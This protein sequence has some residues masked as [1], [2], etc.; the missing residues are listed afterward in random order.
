MVGGAALAVLECLVSAALIT[1]HL[2]HDRALGLLLLAAFGK[3]ALT[4]TLFWTPIMVFL[5][6]VRWVSCRRVAPRP[7]EPFL[8]AAF[9]VLSGV[10]VG[11][12]DLDMVRRA[13][14]AILAAA[15]VGTIVGAMVAYA[16]VGVLRRRCG[17]SRFARR[18]SIIIITCAV[19]TAPCVAVFLSSPLRNP[20]TYALP[21]SATQRSS[22]QRPNVIWIVLDTVRAD[23]MTCYGYQRPTTPFLDEWSR[24]AIVFNRAIANGVWTIPSHASMFTGRSPREHGADHPTIWLDESFKTVADVLGE[25][26]Y[27]TAS[28]SNNPWISHETNLA[29]GFETSRVVYH[30]RHLGR[31]SL[32]YLC[33]RFGVTPP[34]PWLDPDFGAAVTNW[35]VSQWLDQLPDRGQP[36]LLFVNY[37]EG[38]LPYR[39]PRDFRSKFLTDAQVDRSYRLRRRAHGEIVSTMDLRYNIDGPEF[40]P[41]VDREILRGQY[42]AAIRYVDHRVRELLAICDRT[43]LLDN[44]MIVIASDHGEYLGEHGMWSHRFLAYNDV[45]HVTMMMREPGRNS[46]TRVDDPV[47]LADLYPT[48]I[49][50]TD[51]T[52]PSSA[53]AD[54][55]DL[56]AA[57]G[58]R[59]PSR[60]AITEYRGPSVSALRRVR[61]ANT[62]EALHRA[63]PQIAAQ[64]RRFKILASS[65][66]TR[67]LYDLL[68]DPAETH[69]L[70]TSDH[71][72]ARRLDAYINGWKHRVPEFQPTHVRGAELAPDV[73]DAL[74]SLGYLG[75][76]D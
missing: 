55:H 30:L 46:G 23:H 62:V 6:S 21:L 29:K 68:S 2:E 59:D 4:H 64:G 38:H 1:R 48:I 20:G 39:I 17:S 37:M 69:N 53:G 72:E 61:A 36:L 43:G 73:I 65:D 5:A 18:G 22:S 12:A 41:A 63:K 33:A 34:L 7:P 49:N 16:G 42:D 10:V 19:L 3:V 13:T 51:V 56:L 60:V 45:S 14:P 35:L 27:T 32:E 50:V 44:A 52:S 58:E 67:E 74:R 47:Q 75:G 9:I 54:A 57:T 25:A 26:G 71:P 15:G 76:N 70:Y 40:L 28:F 24:G 11:W 31:F 66:G 8:C